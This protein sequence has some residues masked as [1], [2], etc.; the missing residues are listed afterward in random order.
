MLSIPAPYTL[1]RTLRINRG[2]FITISV[3]FLLAITGPVSAATIW[4]IT[5]TTGALGNAISHAAPGDSIVLGP[6][7]YFENAIT[8]SQSITIMAN[9]SLGGNQSNTIIDGQGRGNILWVSTAGLSVA[10]DN[11][12]FRNGNSEVAGAIANN[13][14]LSISSSTFANSSGQGGAIANTGNVSVVSTTFVNCQAYRRKWRC[15]P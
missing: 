7:T 6:G 13:G 5:N 3:L 4:P 15:D 1:P 9:T 12:T 11:L 14:I 10:I 8:I 2:L